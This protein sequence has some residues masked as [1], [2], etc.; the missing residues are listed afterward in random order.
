MRGLLEDSHQRGGLLESKGPA[1]Y[2]VCLATASIYRHLRSSYRWLLSFPVFLVIRN[3]PRVIDVTL[4][5]AMAITILK[6]LEKAIGQQ[7]CG[8][9]S[10]FDTTTANEIKGASAQASPIIA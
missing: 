1:R 2:Q 7:R 10:S 8:T 4:F 3:S 5:V 9:S 6:T